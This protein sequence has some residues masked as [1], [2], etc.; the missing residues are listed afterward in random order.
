[1]VSRL[2]SHFK[3]LANF[4]GEH[5]RDIREKC[6]AALFEAH[7]DTKHADAI[8]RARKKRDE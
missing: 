7:H 4:D 3:A 8:L 6:T 2:T 1:M 5:D